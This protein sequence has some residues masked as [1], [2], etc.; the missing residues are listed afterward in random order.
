MPDGWHCHQSLGGQR[1]LDSQTAKRLS[2][3]H[4]QADATLRAAS[5]PSPHGNRLFTTPARQKILVE[6][7]IPERRERK[8]KQQSEPELKASGSGKIPWQLCSF[9]SISSFQG[10]K[11]SLLSCPSSCV[12]STNVKHPRWCNCTSEPQCFL[13][14]CTCAYCLQYDAFLQWAN[15]TSPSKSP[16]WVHFTP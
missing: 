5:Q 2:H 10:G 15:Q 12:T 3:I 16:I 4:G 1:S 13:A 11:S 6:L 14:Q 7:S 9:C 8:K